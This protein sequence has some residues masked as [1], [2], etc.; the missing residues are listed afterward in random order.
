MGGRE[1][2]GDGGGGG[3]HGGDRSTQSHSCLP[4]LQRLR[5]PKTGPELWPNYSHLQHSCAANTG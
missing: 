2:K 3:T 4:D 1:R 5:V